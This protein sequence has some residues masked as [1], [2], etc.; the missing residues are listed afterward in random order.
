MYTD[1]QQDM[2]REE[3]VISQQRLIDR[4]DDVH[5]IGSLH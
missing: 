5:H 4:E 3:I 1:R 2:D